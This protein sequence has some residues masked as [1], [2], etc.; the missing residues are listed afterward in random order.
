MH[1]LCVS[2]SAYS[3]RSFHLSLHHEQSYLSPSGHPLLG[4]SYEDRS[5]HRIRS[6]ELG[7]GGSLLQVLAI[8]KKVYNITKTLL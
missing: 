4:V 8:E 1:L 6:I 5:F 2:R 3:V 7:Y